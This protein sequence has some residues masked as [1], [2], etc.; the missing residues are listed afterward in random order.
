MDCIRKGLEEAKPDQVFLMF[1]RDIHSDHQLAFDCALS[2]MKPF[3]YP[4]IQRIYSYET[5]SSTEMTA[6][7]PGNAF[8]PNAYCDISDYLEEKIRIMGLYRTEAQDF[9]NPRCSESIRALA[10]FRG[11]SAGVSYAESFMVLRD[12]F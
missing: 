1:G 11:G 7:L 6:P 10:R 9:P 8:V 5:L 12:V 4:G 3:R 2:V